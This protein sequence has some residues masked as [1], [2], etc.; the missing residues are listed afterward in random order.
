MEEIYEACWRGPYSEENL[1]SLTE[2]ENKK[3][4]IYKIYGSHPIYGDNILLY[5]GMTEQG[6]KARLIQHNYWMDE[7]RFGPSRIYF[8]SIGRFENWK[9]SEEIEI[10]DR[11]ERETIENVESLLIYAHQPVHNSKSRNSAIKSKNLRI[12]NTGS[13]GI[14]MPEISGL[15]QE[16]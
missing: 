16:C 11:I 5:I 7:E 3:F 4:V 15:Y 13:F 1:V 9:K 12:F 6:V 8:A 14:L 2:E 10:F